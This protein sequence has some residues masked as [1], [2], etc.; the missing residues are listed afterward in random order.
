MKESVWPPGHR[1]VWNLKKSFFSLINEIRFLVFLPMGL[2]Y[3]YSSYFDKSDL[4][5]HDY[6]YTLQN[7]YFWKSYKQSKIEYKK[8]VK[9]FESFSAII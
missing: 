5:F 7:I 4:S 8:M 1:F 9:N 3:W 2:V 6:R